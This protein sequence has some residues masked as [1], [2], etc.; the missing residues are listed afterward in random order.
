MNAVVMTVGP[1]FKRFERFHGAVT[2]PWT[3]SQAP[4][5]FEARPDRANAAISVAYRG[6]TL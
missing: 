6:A 4:K 1:D 2:L 3:S 5:G